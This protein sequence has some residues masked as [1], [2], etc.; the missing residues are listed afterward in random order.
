MLVAKDLID[1]DIPA[2]KPTDT[3]LTALNW[4]DE[5]K[6]S[7]LPIVDGKICVGLISDIEVLDHDQPEE[8]LITLASSFIKPFITEGD[9]IYEVIK[10]ISQLKLSIIPVVNQD[11]EYLGVITLHDLAQKLSAMASI[12]EPGGIIVLEVNVNDYSLASIAQ[13]V[14]SNDAKILSSNITSIEDSTKIEVTLKINLTDLTR[15]LQTFNR[16]NYNVKA[17]IHSS[18]FIDDVKQRY[19]ML[20]NYINM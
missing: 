11:E 6:V 1:T 12:N 13:I 14:E 19:N 15:V 16:Y 2:L 5:Y 20:M 17:S 10:Q 18:Q 9:H 3:G 8:K 4:M 7:H